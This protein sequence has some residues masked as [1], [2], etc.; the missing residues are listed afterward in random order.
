[1]INET[2]ERFRSEV[3]ALLDEL[4]ILIADIKNPELQ[5]VIKEIQVHVEKPFLF[6]VVGEIKSG[7]SSFINA[8]LQADVCRVDPAPCTDVIQEMFYAPQATKTE[9]NP[10]LHRIPR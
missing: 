1:M 3:I 5:E 8:L 6:V 2:F 7:K 10:F 9:V 4:S